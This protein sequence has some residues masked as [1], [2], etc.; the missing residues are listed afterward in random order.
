[1]YMGKTK[2]YPG[3]NIPRDILILIVQYLL[4]GA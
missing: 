4:F 3:M 1:M 2:K